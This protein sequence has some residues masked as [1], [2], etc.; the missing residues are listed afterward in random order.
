MRQ[1]YKSAEQRNLDESNYVRELKRDTD[2]WFYLPWLWRVKYK[3]EV[4]D[5]G[6]TMFKGSAARSANRA[7]KRHQRNRAKVSDW[8]QV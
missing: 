1:I 7:M 6:W 8:Q 4:F 2:P 3:G 5:L